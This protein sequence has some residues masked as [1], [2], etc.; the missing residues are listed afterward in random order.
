MRRSRPPPD[1]SWM[2]KMVGSDSCPFSACPARATRDNKHGGRLRLSRYPGLI[3]AGILQPQLTRERSASCR[4]AVSVRRDRHDLLWSDCH[5]SP[6]GYAPDEFRSGPRLKFSRRSISEDACYTES[7]KAT[8]PAPGSCLGKRM[9]WSRPGACPK[10]LPSRF[11][12]L[13]IDRLERELC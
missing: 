2:G 8:W 3:D 4:S 1:S 10:P 6:L 11:Q 9:V 13:S 12:P 7:R 5:S